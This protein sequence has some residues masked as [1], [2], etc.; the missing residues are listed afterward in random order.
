MILHL[1]FDSQ[2]SDYVI[3]QFRLEE[4]Q[5]DFVLVSDTNLMQYFQSVDAVR[6]V[7]PSIESEMDQLLEDIAKYKSVIFH[8]LFYEWQEWLLNRWPKHVKVAWV[9]WGGE[10]YAQP[11]I[12]RLFLKPFSKII[13]ILYR[14]RR[15]QRNIEDIFSKELFEKA[16]YLLTNVEAE[17]K[18]VRKY[19]GTGIHYLP[20]NYYSID[21]TLG[22]LKL[23]TV[24]GKNVFLGNS[25]TIENNH[26]EAMLQ[27]KRLGIGN[28]KIV[29]PLSYG[30]PWVRNICLKVGKR[31]F[32][33]NFQPIL[34]FM[35][36][37]EY[38][39]TMLE[40]AVMIQAHLREQA[41]GN[42]VTGL[43]LG[44]RVYLSDKSIDYQHFKLLGCHLYSIEKDLRRS[45][46]NALLPLSADE[47]A[48]N[49]TILLNAY[50][51]ERIQYNVQKIVEV[52]NTD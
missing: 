41:H 32:K 2:F 12:R 3:K 8:G 51:R 10:V 11:D 24:H 50:G 26:F 35:P 52:L 18:F 6:I 20:Y 15:F 16:D 48:H 31:L 22:E 25:A 49:R 19:I 47:I 29:M 45:N 9:C 38:N 43:W 4:M 23:S 1:L 34:K 28:L 39:A 5:S 46:P 44:M 37:V 14:V 40:C 21:E 30:V 42:I 33:D 13:D 7:N 36:R 27:L 17:Y